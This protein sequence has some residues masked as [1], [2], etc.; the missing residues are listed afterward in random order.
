[1][2]EHLLDVAVDGAALVLLD[3]LEL[4]THEAGLAR[5]VGG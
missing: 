3:R 2:R 4:G 5:S 1:L